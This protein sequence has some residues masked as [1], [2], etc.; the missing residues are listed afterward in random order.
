MKT[1]SFLFALSLLMLQSCIVSSSPKMG[2][3]DNPYYDYSDAKFTSINV[4]MFLAKPMVKKALRE[5]GDSEALIALVK[6]ISDVKV[7]TVENGNPQMLGEL[8]KYLTKN[9]FSEWM[10][11]KKENETIDF[12]AKQRGNIIRK[13]LITVKSGNELVFV[14][15]SGKFS[16]D[17]I[18]EMINY[19]QKKDVKK[20]VKN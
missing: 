2:F 13:L 8:A 12:R 19:S 7:M 1:L 9:N 4:P 11:L 15:V 18:S 3:F 14:D 6:K 5:D 16:P 20:L 10:T 17:D